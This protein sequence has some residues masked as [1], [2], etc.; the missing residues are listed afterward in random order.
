MDQDYARLSVVKKIDAGI[1]IGKPKPTWFFRINPAQDQAGA[2]RLHKES[3]DSFY[4]LRPGVDFGISDFGKNFLIFTAI[5]REGEVFL[6]PTKL[7]D[8]SGKLDPCS[9]SMRE[10]AELAKEKWVRLAFNP[11]RKNYDIF[12]A[13]DPLGEPTWPEGDINKRVQV[14]FKGR[15]ISDKDHPIVRGLRGCR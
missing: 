5:N 6:L 9:H 13:E 10:A 4:A 2:L 3:S 11:G 12:V 7:P 15:F 1:H 14:A 8:E